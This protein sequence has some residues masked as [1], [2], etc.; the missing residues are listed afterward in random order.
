MKRSKA[1]RGACN[2]SSDSLIQGH[3]HVINY[4]E[5][6]MPRL[7]AVFKTGYQNLP[8]KLSPNNQLSNAVLFR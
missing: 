2:I 4:K 3:F 6:H 8:Q 5:V 7:S 1:N